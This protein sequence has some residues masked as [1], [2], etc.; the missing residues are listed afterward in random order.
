MRRSP[1][2]PAVLSPGDFLRRASE[3]L[4]ALLGERAN[5]L[6]PTVVSRLKGRGAE[7]NLLRK[8]R[9]LRDDDRSNTM[10]R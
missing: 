6:S 8:R 1:R 9:Q 10:V 4:S 2:V 5:G 3:V 7:E